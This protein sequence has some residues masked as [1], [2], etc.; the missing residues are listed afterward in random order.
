MSLFINIFSLL[1][2]KRKKQHHVMGHSLLMT[3]IK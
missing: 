1:K 3:Q 2:K